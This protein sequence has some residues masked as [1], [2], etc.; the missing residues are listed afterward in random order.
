MSNENPT[1]MDPARVIT[2]ECGRFPTLYWLDG[3]RFLVGHHNLVAKAKS[4]QQC[5]AGGRAVTIARWEILILTNSDGTKRTVS[6]G[7]VK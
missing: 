4:T 1:P 5:K 2:C 7:V 6:N 3:D